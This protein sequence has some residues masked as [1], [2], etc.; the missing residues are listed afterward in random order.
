MEYFKSFSQQNI[1]DLIHSTQKK[2]YLCLPAIHEE[3]NTAITY[4]D[5]SNSHDGKG[6]EI[7]ILVDLDANTFRQGYGDFRSVEDLWRGVFNVKTLPDNR[8]S[9][10]ISD[11]VGYYLFI[12]SRSMIPAEKATINAIRI[13]SV[14]QVRLKKYFFGSVNKKDFE[15]ELTN[16][17]IEES[18]LLKK[19][20]ELV[21]QNQAHVKEITQADIEIV[22]KDLSA[23]PPLHPDYKRLV[24]FYSNKFQ[25]VRLRFEGSNLQHRKIE[26][27][28]KALPIADTDLKER[29]ETKLNLFEKKDYEVVFAPLQSL[30]N[31]IEEIREKYLTKIKS[32]EESL[33][34]KL[35]KQSFEKEIDK[36]KK[37]IIEIQKK[38]L[39]GVA[40]LINQTK[41]NLLKELTQFLKENPRTLF[42]QHPHLW[43][44]DL[45]YL[46]S[47][48]ESKAS[49]IIYRIKW[50]EA[51]VL[52]S[53]FKME[54]QYS[55]ITFEDL[56]NKE[57]IKELKACGL[58]DTEDE[59]QL[60][61]FGKGIGTK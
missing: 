24:E 28:A 59:N 7:H 46:Q 55:E 13:D 18:I 17:I 3:L 47:S 61:E 29:L 50:P 53:D 16:A 10:I 25:Y 45:D 1:I 27:P 14:S 37:G 33:L 32:R 56:K 52:I 58:I 20:D 26:L 9:F 39:V 5:Y 22:S 21:D 51:H 12:E 35:E 2:L 31:E 40:K 4:L 43:E 49:E 30:K 54:A 34:N 11:E 6:I 57:F 19:I 42:P 41:A 36:L 23:N 60:A 8:I 38:L 15:N 48:A 44:N